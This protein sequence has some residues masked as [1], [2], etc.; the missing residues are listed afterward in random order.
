VQHRH[1]PPLTVLVAIQSGSSRQV[2]GEVTTKGRKTEKTRTYPVP[3]LVLLRW[4]AEGPRAVSS[5]RT[6][7][8]GLVRYFFVQHMRHCSLPA[9]RYRQRC[10]HAAVHNGR[11]LGQDWP[12]SSDC[13]GDPRPGALPPRLWYATQFSARHL[14]CIL[15][16][17]RDPLGNLRCTALAQRCNVY[18]M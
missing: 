10:E 2:N 6:G 5:I 13:Q 7:A 3:L 8:Q 15:S 9:G 11:V 4:G 1:L 18:S 12:R 17:S 16:V 14:I